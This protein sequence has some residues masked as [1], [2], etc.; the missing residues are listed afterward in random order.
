M[1]R[2]TPDDLQ[3][4][5]DREAQAISALLL[6]VFSQALL[7]ARE[8]LLRCVPAAEIKEWPERGHMVHLV[9]PDRFPQASRSSP[10]HAFNKREGLHSR[11]KH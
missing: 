2:T 1:L 10:T 8:Y 11:R 9:D 5:I 6:V 3:A 7:K 4:R